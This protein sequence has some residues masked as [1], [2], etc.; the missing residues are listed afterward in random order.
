[1]ERGDRMIEYR[2][3]QK[4]YKNN[5]IA[6][7][8][9]SFK[10]EKGE[11]VFLVGPSGAGKTTLLKMMY[12]EE[13]PTNGS[14][15]LFGQDIGEIKTKIVR[16][17][18]GVVFQDFSLLPNKTAYENVAFALECVGK[19]PFYVK[20]EAKR[21]LERLGIHQGLYKKKPDQLS[22][23]EQQRVAIA[24]AI[25]N[26]PQILVCDEP[27]GNLDDENATI[28]MR[29]LDE[30]NQ[31][32][33]TIIMSTHNK[34]IVK[35]MNKRVLYV[36]EGRVSNQQHQNYFDLSKYEDESGVVIHRG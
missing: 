27:T 10:I 23:G 32:G 14:I 20:R 12:K 11:F 9:A 30:L 26:N 25:V 4:V 31:K 19:N 33:T 24:R 21:A 5:D 36:E 2:S 16:R 17:N 29:Y 22:G 3:V 15:I 13:K 8:N 6:I 1:M 28:L 18:V 7:K 34:E 35:Q